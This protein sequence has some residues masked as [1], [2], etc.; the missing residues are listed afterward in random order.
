[1]KVDEQIQF[2]DELTESV[3]S[4]VVHAIEMGRV[5]EDWDGLE[6]RELLADKFTD[7]AGWLKRNN[8]KRYAAYKNQMLVADI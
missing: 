6:L 7:S 5:P 3:R 2:V 8:R 1:M 4:G